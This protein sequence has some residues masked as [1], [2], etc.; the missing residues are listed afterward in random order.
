M[1]G[2]ISDRTFKNHNAES[3]NEEYNF[4]YYSHNDLSNICICTKPQLRYPE[5]MLIIPL[6]RNTEPFDREASS[7]LE[8]K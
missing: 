3:K 8:T 6:D 1:K 7:W 4:N 5:N 2:I